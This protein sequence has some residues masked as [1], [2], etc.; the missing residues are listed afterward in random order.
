MN[1]GKSE[2]QRRRDNLAE[3][4][5]MAAGAG[6]VTP[7]VSQPEAKKPPGDIVACKS[8]GQKNRVNCTVGEV[9]R[10]KKPVCGKCK[11]EL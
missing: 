4:F 7:S 2:E 11:A 6:L 10:G 5:R 1:A 3:I 9:L 8:C